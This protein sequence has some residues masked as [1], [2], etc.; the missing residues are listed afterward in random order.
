MVG[1]GV[2][3]YARSDKPE[4]LWIQEDGAIL[5]MARWAHER[6]TVTDSVW[7][8][9]A[10]AYLGDLS[11]EDGRE[12]AEQ[13]LADRREGAGDVLPAFRYL[14]A[15]HEGNAWLQE[16][17]I[18]RRG[19]PRYQVIRRDGTQLGWV[20]TPEG[21]TILDIAADRILAYERDEWDV[22]AVSVYRINKPTVQG[23]D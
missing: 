6:T 10:D 14:R 15:D 20:E 11:Q 23:G 12:Q 5:Q 8:A 21:L 1:S 16:Y 2:V 9:Y 22:Q 13:R 4:V 7:Q 18:D 3:L 17:T 19:R